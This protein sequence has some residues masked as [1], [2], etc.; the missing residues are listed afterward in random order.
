MNERD[1][2]LAYRAANASGDRSTGAGCHAPDAGHPADAAR[3]GGEE[4]GEEEIEVTEEMI[5]AGE[6]AICAANAELSPWVSYSDLAEKVYRAMAA[7]GSR[8]E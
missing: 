4:T 2:P 6:D 3:H 7:R 5:A 1:L 8:D